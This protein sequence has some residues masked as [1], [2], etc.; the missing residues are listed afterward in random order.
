MAAGYQNFLVCC[1]MFAASIALRF[2]FSVN[3]YADNSPG[4]QLCTCRPVFIKC[5]CCAGGGATITGRP[6]SQSGAVQGA[7][8]DGQGPVSLQSI[9]SSLKETMNPRDIMQD[10]IHNFHPQYSQYTQVRWDK[11]LST[12]YHPT[13][14]HIESVVQVRQVGPLMSS[15]RKYAYKLL[16]TNLPPP[17]EYGGEEDVIKRAG[18]VDKDNVVSSD[19]DDHRYW[20]HRPIVQLSSDNDTDT[21]KIID[22]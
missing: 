9:S 4:N 8:N 20:P 21:M 14:T 18:V 19:S 11:T 10:A 17:Y 22:I 1:E 13:N 15:R 7:S 16:L 2:A 3:V 5:A 6:L 12:N